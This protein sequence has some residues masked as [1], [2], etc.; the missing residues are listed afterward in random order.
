MKKLIII[1]A[2]LVSGCAGGIHPS[3]NRSYSS[4][5]ATITPYANPKLF[6]NLPE[7]DG[8]PIP[9]A[10]YSFTDRTGQRKSMQTVSSFSTA[11]TQGAD[12]YVVKTLHDVNTGH[13]FRP[14]ERVSIDSLIKERQLIRQ[15]REQEKGEAADPLPPLMVAGILLEGGVIDY[16]SDVKTGGNGVR[17]LGIGPHTQYIQDQVTINMRLVSVQTGEILDSV[18]VQKSL[19]STSEGITALKFFNLGTN[20]FEIDSQQTNNEAGSYAIR[21]AIETGIV[22]LIKNGEKKGLWH[23]KPSKTQE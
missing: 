20:A 14:V 12:A 15:M 18:T 10:V 23:F 2:F 16:N 21:S 11:V 3:L 17:Y 22:E 19:L 6:E 13:W 9:I 1:A 4:A 5:P 7:L 8:E